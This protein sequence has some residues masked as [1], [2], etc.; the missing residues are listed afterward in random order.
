MQC[1]PVILEKA[2]CLLD[3]AFCSRKETAGPARAGGNLEGVKKQLR[4]LLAL[5]WDVTFLS[6][7]F[8][9]ET[10]CMRRHFVASLLFSS[11]KIFAR[12]CIR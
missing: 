6:Q 7:H 5:L 10:V 9:L 4:L 3:D 2:T 12:L 1:M 8:F 11:R